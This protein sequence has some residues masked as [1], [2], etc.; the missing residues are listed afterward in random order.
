M[1]QQANEIYEFGR[2]HLDARERLLL[3]DGVA[4]SLTPKSFDLLLA[5]IERAGKL[6]EKEELFQKVWPDT[7]VEESNLSSNIALI[8]KAL[9][10][11]MNGK[12]YIETVPK[13]GYRFVAEVRVHNEGS[14][15]LDVTPKPDLPVKNVSLRGPSKTLRRRTLLVC[16]ALILAAT[17]PVYLTL[18]S[19]WQTPTVT[20]YTQLTSD[21]R[22]KRD[23]VVTDGS[24]VYFSEQLGGQIVVAQVSTASGETVPLQPQ[25]SNGNLLAISPDKS[26]LL[27]GRFQASAPECP[28]WIVPVTGG[29]PYRLGDVLA[30]AA[31]WTANGESITYANGGDLFQVM[32]DGSKSLKL[33]GLTGRIDW[34]RWSPDGKRVRFTVRDTKTLSP[35]IWEAPADGSNPHPLFPD[36]NNPEGECCGNWS[37]DGKYFV[38]ES[39]R[40]RR[41]DIWVLAEESGLF[42]R[43]RREPVQLT[44][45]PMNFRAPV[46]S[47]DGSRIFVIGQQQRGELIRYNASTRQFVSHLSGLSAENLSFSADG[48]WMSYVTYP[49]G[50]LWRSKVDGSQRLQLS[51]P[52][53][54]ARNAR[55]SPD[56]NRIA[57]QAQRPGKAWKI[58]MVSRD[59]GS[60]QQLMLEDREERDPSWSRDGN[61]LVFDARSALGNRSIYLLDLRTNQ[62]SLL[63]GAT[64]MFSQRWSPDGR[65]IAALPL[66]S[67]KLM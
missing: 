19:R 54:H 25:L 40:D 60:P 37:V 59:G 50:D 47:A 61:S 15:A 46:P 57:F 21:G 62:A 13:R 49:E 35:K 11:G 33:L 2:L 38:F 7:I 65:Y 20:R 9:G 27:I 39:V 10:D 17:V 23:A 12:R 26:K 58:H 63:A 52:P 48:E 32:N 6:V 30:H 1:S 28:L 4:I 44:F 3:R 22:S 66:D 56:G 14:A 51:F 5:L 64:R 8:R 67:K 41:S 18:K 42:A 43:A 16:G 24:R 45:G 36:W 31:T 34:V 55:W 53:L 29:S